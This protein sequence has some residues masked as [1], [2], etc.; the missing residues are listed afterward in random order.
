MSV[1]L[2]PETVEEGLELFLQLLHKRTGPLY[3]KFKKILKIGNHEKS[4]YDGDDCLI[5][6]YIRQ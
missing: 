5:S 1:N 2:G 3:R 6:K 4:I